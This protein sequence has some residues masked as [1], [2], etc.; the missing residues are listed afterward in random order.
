MLSIPENWWRPSPPSE[1]EDDEDSS[2][3][4][5]NTD[6]ISLPAPEMMP[7][8]HL[9]FPLSCGGSKFSGREYGSA[10]KARRLSRTT[11]PP[12]PGENI[13]NERK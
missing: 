8:N 2:L 13:G 3:S 6:E 11:F 12:A 4:E 5:R 1:D 9:G 10:G 7:E